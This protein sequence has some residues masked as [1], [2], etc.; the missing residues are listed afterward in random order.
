M[1]STFS[2][3]LGGFGVIGFRTA[4]IDVFLLAVTETCTGVTFGAP[5][6]YFSLTLRTL[7][8]WGTINRF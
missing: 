7:T 8:S 4:D 6:S 2:L 3:V 5:S 1:T